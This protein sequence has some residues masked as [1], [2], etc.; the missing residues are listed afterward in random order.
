MCLLKG[1]GLGGFQFFGLDMELGLYSGRG[2]SR[3]PPPSSSLHRLSGQK[4]SVAPYVGQGVLPSTAVFFPHGHLLSSSHKFF[5]GSRL[6]GC[7]LIPDWWPEGVPPHAHFP[8]FFHSPPD[9]CFLCLIQLCPGV[10]IF[11][12]VLVSWQERFGTFI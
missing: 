9:I 5:G 2:G 11:C 7:C 3:V 6:C 4:G 8:L 1:G 12:P 10:G